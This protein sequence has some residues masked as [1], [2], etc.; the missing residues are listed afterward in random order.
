[1]KL[2]KW[3]KIAGIVFVIVAIFFMVYDHWFDDYADSIEMSE[4]KNSIRIGED[5]VIDS[6]SI[7]QRG[8]GNDVDIEEGADIDGLDVDQ[9]SD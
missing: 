4:S 1:M 2:G 8:E 3:S 5:A 7:K 6:T 9:E